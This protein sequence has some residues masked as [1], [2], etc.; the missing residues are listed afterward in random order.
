MVGAELIDCMSGKTCEIGAEP[1][2]RSAER[3]ACD[4]ESD[5]DD[6]NGLG[7]GP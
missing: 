3:V 4:V 2:D 6:G 1:M 5:G 7:N